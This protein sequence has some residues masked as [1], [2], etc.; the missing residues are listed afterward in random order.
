MIVVRTMTTTGGVRPGRKFAR[1]IDRFA[2]MLGHRNAKAWIAAEMERQLLK[3]RP[4]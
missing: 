4:S 3:H 1:R 2:R